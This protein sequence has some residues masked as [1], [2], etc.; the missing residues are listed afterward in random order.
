MDGDNWEKIRTKYNDILYFENITFENVI[1]KPTTEP[2][3]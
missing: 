3:S 2:I 1:M